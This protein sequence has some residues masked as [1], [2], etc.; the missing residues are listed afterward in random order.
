[1]PERQEGGRHAAFFAKKAAKNSYF[2][3]VVATAVSQPAICKSFLFLF[4]KK[5]ALFVRRRA[6]ILL[7]GNRSA[8]SLL[9]GLLSLLQKPSS[10][11]ASASRPGC[12]CR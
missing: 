1:L 5:E 3:W 9:P 2:S 4:F 12:H 6:E 10:S 8:A 11:S 7:C